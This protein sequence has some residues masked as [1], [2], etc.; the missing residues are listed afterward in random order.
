[1]RAQPAILSN[2]GIE[3][4]ALTASGAAQPL[5]PLHVTPYQAFDALPDCYAD[6][7]GEMASANFSC[8][9]AWFTAFAHTALQEGARLRLYGVESTEPRTRAFALLVAQTPAA[10]RGSI[11]RRRHIGEQTLS[12]LTGYQTYLYAPLVRNEDPRYEEI[13][14]C[15]AQHL[16]SERPRWEFIDF[17][18]MDAEARSYDALAAALRRAGYV[19]YRYPHFLGM[20]EPTEGQD[21]AAYLASRPPSERKQI[22]NYERKERKL[23]EQDAFEWR[24]FTSE[25]GLD[26]ALQ[27]Y[28]AVLDASWKEPDHHPLFLPACIRAAAQAGALRLGILYLEGKPAATQLVFLAGR[29][30][31]F[32]RTAYDPA[33]ARHSAGAMVKRC[34]VQHLLDKDRTVDEFDFGRD[35]E[36]FKRIWA[37]RERTRCGILACDRRTAGGWHALAAHSLFRCRERVGEATRPIRARIIEAWQQ[38]R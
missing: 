30:A 14:D 33:F 27:D 28:A 18:A 11:L 4:P 24:L 6:L 5:A 16:R 13:L 10:R 15:L 38:K 22:R 26:Q 7:L 2:G 19:T 1:M 8:S 31:V 25:A 17:S 21:Y 35:R 12:G 23:R 37:T 3:N 20:Y 34:M 32:Y 29:R 36:S 9:Q